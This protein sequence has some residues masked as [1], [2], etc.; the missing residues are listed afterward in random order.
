MARTND[1]SLQQE[2]YAWL[3]AN[4]YA[5]LATCDKKQPRVRPVVLFYIDDR[6]WVVTFSGDSKVQQIADNGAIEVCLPLTEAGHTG[7]IRF[8]G[9]ARIWRDQTEKREAM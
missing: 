9:N 1:S 7:Y 5:Y 3:K 4:Q 8:S 2:I 6:F